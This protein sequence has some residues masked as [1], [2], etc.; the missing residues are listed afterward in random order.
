MERNEIIK[1]LK[2]YFS[3]E[4]F[5]DKTTF[6][7]HGERAWKFFDTNLLH[8]ILIIRV[9]LDKS[10]TINNWS[11][12]GKFSQRG[13]RTNI[14]SI[15][16]KKTEAL[17]LYLS[18]HLFGKAVD[19]DV[20]GMSAEE[21]RDWIIENAPLFPCKIRLEHKFSSTGKVINWV[22]LDIFEEEKNPKIYLFN[23]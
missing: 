15:V 6:K 3:I 13:L 1:Q 16:K 9:N 23:V 14:C 22:H 19:F 18:A 10:M 7:A 2:S 20:K 17:R 8:T 5:V 11:F 12:G 21:V 4:E